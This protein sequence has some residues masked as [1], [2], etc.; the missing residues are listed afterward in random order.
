MDEEPEL[1]AYRDES[2]LKAPSQM[3]STL[4]ASFEETMEVQ[5]KVQEEEKP[6]KVQEEAKE[7]IGSLWI[8]MRKEL[9]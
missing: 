7:E 2:S 3:D 1:K 8:L 5:V 4:V 6:T 9:N